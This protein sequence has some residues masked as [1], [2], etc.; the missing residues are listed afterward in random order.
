LEAVARRN[1]IQDF[2][3]LID[4]ASSAIGKFRELAVTLKI[5]K[6]LMDRIESDF[7]RV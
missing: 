1:D 4:K 3:S 7:V 2:K 6:Q 5:D